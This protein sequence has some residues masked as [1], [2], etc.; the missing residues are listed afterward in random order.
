M[1]A[2]LKRSSFIFLTPI[3]SLAGEG[4]RIAVALLVTLAISPSA[5]AQPL[6]VDASGPP[7]DAFTDVVYVARLLLGLPPVP[8]GFRVLDPNIPPDSVIAARV[9]A[10]GTALDVDA[11]GA[12]DVFTDVVYCAR[13]LLNLPPVP[14]SFRAGDPSIPPDGEIADR[15]RTLLAV[16]PT[17]TPSRTPTDTPTATRTATVSVTATASVTETRTPS[18]TVTIT[19]TRTAVPTATSTATRTRTPTSTRT[20]TGTPTR[21]ATPTS[22]ASATGTATATG[23]VTATPTNTIGII[24]IGRAFNQPGGITPFCFEL[25][26]ATDIA[27]LKVDFCVDPTA[28]DV[29]AIQCS[30]VNEGS[31][32]CIDVDTSTVNLEGPLFFPTC[33]L[34]APDDPHGQVQA[35]AE[36]TVEDLGLPLGKLLGC[37]VPVRPETLPGDYPLDA[38]VEVTR[39]TGETFVVRTSGLATVVG[40]SPGGEC[41]SD[42]QCTSPPVCRGGRC[43]ACECSGTCDNFGECAP[44]PCSP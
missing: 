26:N 36:T 39:L 4:A 33:E 22:T 14:P 3:L 13:L 6:D 11:G 27:S 19:A 5:G 1:H 8:P 9:V 42:P 37:T 30:T 32:F 24:D 41:V 2:R 35:T 31:L 16:P 15:C 29:G 34:D 23:T 17:A 38:R 25:Q 21:T 12:V 18:A 20:L 43:C 10:L 40:L 28:F 7:V 44:T